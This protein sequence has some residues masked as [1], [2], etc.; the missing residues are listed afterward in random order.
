MAHSKEY[1]QRILCR[2]NAARKLE[3][4]VKN[5]SL[6]G[7]EDFINFMT[8]NQITA[9]D[10]GPNALSTLTALDV[11]FFPQGHGMDTPAHATAAR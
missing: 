1:S 10:I 4:L 8:K 5:P 2:S 3:A 11:R 7:Y 9:E 6:K